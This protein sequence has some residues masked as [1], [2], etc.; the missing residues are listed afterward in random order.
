[1]QG[2]QRLQ[3]GHDLVPDRVP[4]VLFLLDPDALA[5]RVL[6]DPLQQFRQHIGEQAQFIAAAQSRADPAAG[7]FRSFHR[8]LHRGRAYGEQ[9]DTAD[10]PQL[11][12]DP[13]QQDRRQD[14]EDKHRKTTGD[15]ANATVDAAIVAGQFDLEVSDRCRDRASR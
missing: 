7:S 8:P 6:V 5:L 12:G 13:G 11:N 3:W 9:G 14:S 10:D 2:G 1:M 15:Q 4:H